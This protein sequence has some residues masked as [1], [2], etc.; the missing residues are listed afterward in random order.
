M[1]QAWLFNRGENYQ[2]YKM[3][4]AR[5][6]QSPEGNP[7]YRFAVW[8]PRAAAVSV[9]GDFNGW[10]PQV[11]HLQAYGTTGIWH[12]FV[13]GALDWQHYKYAIRTSSG[14]ILLKADPFA[15]HAETRPG[16][17]SILYQ[18]DHDYQWTDHEFMASRPD[19]LQEGPLNIY[20]LHLGSWRRY[21]DG[22]VYNYRD[23]ARQ[24]ADYCL[25][26]GY[27]AVELMP[28]MEYPLDA[29]W[30]YQV[31]GY[32]APTSRYGTPADLKYLIDLLHGAGIR[33]I[34]DWVPS[35]FPRD[36]FA[37]ARF[38]GQPLFEDPDS[39]RGEH[40]DWGTLVFNYGLSEVRSFLL[41]SAWYWL[42]EFHV[43]GL[44]V[45]AVSSMLYLDF[46][47]PGAQPNQEGTFEHL[48]AIEFLK[49]M[50]GLLR[51]HFPHCILAAE[52][53]TPYPGITLP[54]EEGGLG[55]THKWNMGWMNDT[56]AYME[57]DYHARGQ[58]H[59][60][61]T[62]SMT[63]AF[64][65][66]F[67][68]PFSH[69]EVVHGKKTL[70]G[71]MP[72]DYWRQFASLR[73]C[74]MYQMSQPGAKLNFM[75]NEFAPYLEWRYYEELE[76]FMLAY[77]RHGQMH[78][79]VRKLNHLYLRHPALWDLERSWEGF[80]WLQADDRDRSIFI[81]ARKAQAGDTMLVVLNMTPASYND[82]PIPVPAAGRY[83]LILNSDSDQYGGS[84]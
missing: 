8:A 29:S 11:D 30:G 19:A 63:Y 31:T 69:D 55:F 74:Y 47:R 21:A 76:W 34:L 43:D 1:N 80:Q 15:R 9:V 52:E 12:G 10:D 18:A 68:L 75:G 36:E 65:E 5:P 39:R 7:G 26:M 57:T 48:E 61:I 35:H 78:E 81:Y 62:F 24:L 22:H 46:G 32:F 4:G 84:G 14:R 42:D 59:E 40:Q 2:S 17:A 28:V 60:K 83:R 37:L 13:E 41:S 53:S 6:H 16:T 3:L 73:T 50:N 25:V 23:I 27:N 77:P 38:D 54:V 64:S 67:I 71:R 51:R 82:Y 79:F 33:V 20:E 58:V 70:L 56:L 66:N 72:G 49:K 45:D 44:R